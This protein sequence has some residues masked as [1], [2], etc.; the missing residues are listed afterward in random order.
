MKDESIRK[1]LEIIARRNIPENT[2]LWPRLASRLEHKDMV[3]M[4]MKWKLVWTILLVLLGLSAVTGVAY[5]FYRYFN[6]AGLQSVSNAGLISTVNVTAQPTILPTGTPPEP[7]T[8]IGDSQTLEGVSLTLDWVYLMDGRQA[9]GFSAQ[10]LSDGKTLGMPKMGFGPLIPEQYRGAGM[11]LK[12]DTQPVTG[13]YF[14][15][16][17]V[18]DA[19]T[20]TITDTYTDVSVEMPLLDGNGKV[21]NTFR[22]D[23]KHELMHAGPYAGGNIYSTRANGLEMTLDWILLTSRTVRARLCFVPPDGKD[24]SLVAPTI[25]LGA[26]PNLVVSA[27]SVTALGLTSLTDEAGIRCQQVTF[28][29]SPADAQAFYLTVNKLVSSTGEILTGDWEFDWNQLPGRMQFPGIAPLEAP[30]DSQGIRSDLTV[31]LEKAYADVNR[32]VFVVFIKSS[33]AGLLASGA[34]LQDSSGRDLNT[35]AM[36]IT[37]P[38]DDPTRFIIEFDPSIAFAAGQFKGQLMVAIGT[39]FMPGSGLPGVPFASG[40]GGGGGGGDG[41]AAV[42]A[43]PS[44]QAEV[45][46]PV[47]LTVFPAITVDLMQTVTAN[48]VALLLQKVELTPSFAQVYLCYQKPSPA[49]WHLGQAVSLQIGSDSTGQGS[50]L[51]LFDSDLGISAPEGWSSP[52]KTG[53]CEKVGFPVGHHNRPETLTLAIPELEQSMPDIIPDGQLQAARQK[54]LAQGIDMDWVTFS[55]NGGGGAG[56]EIQKKPAGMTEEQVMRLFFEELGYYYP[57]PWTFTVEINP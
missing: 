43:P 22:F 24:W 50:G 44:G 27:A 37:S 56:P 26:D 3:S 46:F 18:R 53:R 32:M 25:Q 31:T 11:A 52:V 16:Q 54:L 47:D 42:V 29:V 40:G 15:N 35:V 4:N 10:G 6:D 8:V 49:D 21:L 55:G 2:N 20:Y 19:A 51:P 45:H 12:D 57:G 30:L 34:A 36:G 38:P 5:A 23:I 28:P 14:V 39:Q 9:F 33:Q 48:G 7:V 41:G 17:I 13:A 1:S